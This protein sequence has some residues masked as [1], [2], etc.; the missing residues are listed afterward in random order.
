MPK[1]WKKV[2]VETLEKNQNLINFRKLWKFKMTTAENLVQLQR[3]RLSTIQRNLQIESDSSIPQTS[4]FVLNK[5]I[6]IYGNQYQEF[7]ETHDQLSAELPE[8]G[9][10]IEKY[11]SEEICQNF[12]KIYFNLFGVLHEA[13][14]KLTSESG[15]II[16]T[17]IHKPKVKL[18]ILQPP[19][20]NSKYI[21]WIP[22]WDQFTALID[23]NT[24]LHPVQKMQ[25][26]QASLK[27]TAINIIKHLPISDHSYE[28][29]KTLLKRRFENPRAIFSNAMN[30]LIT[31]PRGKKDIITDLQYLSAIGQE[32]MQTFKNIEVK[33]IETIIAYLMIDKFSPEIRKEFE[34][35]LSTETALLPSLDDVENQI[36]ISIRTLESLET[37]KIQNEMPSK[38]NTKTTVK[39]FA[40]TQKRAYGEKTKNKD[41]INKMNCSLCHGQHHIRN[42]NDFISLPVEEKR[43]KSEAL[44]LC[45]NCLFPN[46]LR[47]KCLIKVGCKTCGRNHH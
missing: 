39:S 21:E 20:F 41:E 6:E 14:I 24:D 37:G 46:H 47:T 23:K 10:I 31:L 7:H 4:T 32:I 22:F 34:K 38:E 17:P 2:L 16:E 27:G 13:L 44:Q 25:Y 33:N 30:Q 36:Q 19:I 1:P 8:K 40:M 3:T 11:F 45:Y 12:E 43:T 28:I 29:A 18:P 9:S 26:L 15:I 42:C 35:K 5:K